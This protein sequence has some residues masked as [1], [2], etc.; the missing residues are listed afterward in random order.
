[1]C[2]SDQH[3]IL[4]MIKYD[5]LKYVSE[6]RAIFRF[7]DQ[8]HLNYSALKCTQSRIRIPNRGYGH[9]GKKWILGR[10]QENP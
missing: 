2:A 1:M 7:G 5:I 8:C 9:Q 3:D 6:Y 4:K 10:R